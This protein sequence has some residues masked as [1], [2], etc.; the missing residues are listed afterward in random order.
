MFRKYLR[1]PGR[2]LP[3]T[4]PCIFR[5]QDFITCG[6]DGIRYTF[7]N[8]CSSLFAIAAAFLTI[9]IPRTNQ[10]YH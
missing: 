8:G 7:R 2:R 6:N 4:D 10:E 9:T 1:R 5:V 3:G